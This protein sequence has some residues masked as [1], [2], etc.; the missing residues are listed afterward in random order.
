L[1]DQADIMLAKMNS[2]PVQ[3]LI[4]WWFV[5]VGTIVAALSIRLVG[6]YAF[7]LSDEQ[8]RATALFSAFTLALLVVIE[9]FFSEKR[10]EPN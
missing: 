1:K 4:A 6:H 7:G 10:R 3:I 8:I 5:V 2:D 9:H